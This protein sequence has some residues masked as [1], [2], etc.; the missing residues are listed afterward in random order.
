MSHFELEPFPREL[1]GHEGFPNSYRVYYTFRGR[2][3]IGTIIYMTKLKVFRTISVYASAEDIKALGGISVESPEEWTG[4]VS[5]NDTSPI[6]EARKLY[7]MYRT[8]L[9]IKESIGR[10]FDK[11]WPIVIGFSS[12]IISLSSIPVGVL[13][14]IEIISK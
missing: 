9:G 2:V 7:K 13:A 11:W 4:D 10:A 6:A 5:Y 8:K 14:F 3:F 12:I 1:D